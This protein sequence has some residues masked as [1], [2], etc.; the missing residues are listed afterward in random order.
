MKKEEYI[1]GTRAI[2]EAIENSRTIDRV[3]IKKGLKNEMFHTLF[4]SVKTNQIP[5]QFV[6]I[7]RLNRITHKNHQGVVAFLSPVE[8]HNIQT[9]LP[10]IFEKGQDPFILILDQITDV[11]NF[12][13]IVR[14]AE[15]AGVH[16]VIVPEK[17]AAQIGADAMKTSAGAL[18]HLPVCREKNLAST[19]SFLKNSGIKVIAANEKSEKIY[20]SEKMDVPLAIIMGS[21]ENGISGEVMSSAGIQ[22]KIP[23]L[24]KIDSLNVSVATAVILYEAVRQKSFL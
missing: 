14:S 7:E 16:A 18:N 15:C 19:I 10:G 22:V 9:L 1:F 23:V 13:A 17:G 21:E 4:H 6:P 8:F 2:L 24:G 3:L 20:S 12:G 11:R 5:Y